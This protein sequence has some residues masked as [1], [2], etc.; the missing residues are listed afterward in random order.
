MLIRH[1]SYPVNALPPDTSSTG[2]SSCVEGI[3]VVVEMLTASSFGWSA[4][5]EV[6]VE[7]S[8]VAADAVVVLKVTAG[9]DVAVVVVEFAAVA[10]DVVTGVAA[11]VEVDSDI[12]PVGDTSVGGATKGDPA[13]ADEAV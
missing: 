6:A 12:T 9:A 8:I 13:V 1:F 2:T 10:T 11:V 3:E 4:D 7:L 5:P